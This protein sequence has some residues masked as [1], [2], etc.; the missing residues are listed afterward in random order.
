MAETTV[1]DG[2]FYHINGQ[3]AYKTWYDKYH[4]HSRHFTFLFN[5]FVFLQVFNFVCCRRIKDEINI[6]SNICSSKLFWIIVCL[7]VILQA[8][9]VTFLGKFFQ[10]Y[11]YGGLNMI[12]WLLS[13]GFGALTIPV[14][15][16]LRVLPFWK[17]QDHH[18]KVH[19]DEL[20]EVSIQTTNRKYIQP[21]STYSSTAGIPF[22]K[23]SSKKS[24]SKKS[25]ISES[26]PA[27]SANLP[28]GYQ[29]NTQFNQPR[30]WLYHEFI[31]YILSSYTIT[32]CSSLRIMHKLF[33]FS[34]GCRLFSGCYGWSCR[35]SPP[36]A[37][38]TGSLQSCPQS[39]HQLAPGHQ[40][41]IRGGPPWEP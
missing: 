2:K 32:V 4:N 23:L 36:P 24:I 40:W 13:I 7:I 20:D 8:L 16:F 15:L 5:T 22:T 29:Y 9:V 28:Y 18:D 19:I 26:R 21:V 37:W 3:D 35:T 34:S 6:F 10:L 1:A 30:Y 41:R 25:S 27:A 12:Q 17:H 11:Q 33:L 31:Y 14:S 39:H 38:K